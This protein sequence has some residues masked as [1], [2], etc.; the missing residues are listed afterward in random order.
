[1]EQEQTNQEHVS[2]NNKLATFFLGNLKTKDLVLTQLSDRTF[3]FGAAKISNA[4]PNG[5]VLSTSRVISNDLHIY[6]EGKV[7]INRNDKIAFTDEPNLAN[8][9]PK[10]LEVSLG[11]TKCDGNPVVVLVDGGGEIRVGDWSVENTGTLTIR[12]GTTLIIGNGGIVTVESNAKIVVINGGVLKILDSGTLNVSGDG[13]IIVE[14][15]GV[16]LVEEDAGIVLETE[17]LD[18]VLLDGKIYGS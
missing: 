7:W 2:L 18:P 17:M 13:R 15:G 11:K 8:T 3:N 9:F 10:E 16:L 6:N 14:N 12:E 4:L 5:T 1:F